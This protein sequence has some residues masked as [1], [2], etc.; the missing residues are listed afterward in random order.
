[1]K[2]TL[3]LLIPMTLVLCGPNVGFAQ[4]TAEP[5]GS[6]KLLPRYTHQPLRGIDTLVGKISR[7]DGLTIQYD[8][9]TLAGN[10][11]M[12]Q[13]DEAVWFKEHVINGQTVQMAFSK[14]KELT[15]TFTNGPANFFATVKSEEDLADV[16][17]MLATYSPSRK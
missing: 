17:L 11:A 12:A 15:V 9:G 6:I 3:A 1:M 7:E 5:P 16:L 14:S 8:I 10:Y 4:R 2:S 13:K